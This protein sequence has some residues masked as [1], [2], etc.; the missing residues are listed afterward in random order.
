MQ[1]RVYAYRAVESVG[2]PLASNERRWS[3]DAATLTRPGLPCSIDM[4]G[5][6]ASRCAK[7]SGAQKLSNVGEHQCQPP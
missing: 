4:I 3:F 7:G 5:C 6:N 2:A 1:E